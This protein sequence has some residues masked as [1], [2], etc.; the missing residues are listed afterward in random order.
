MKYRPYPRYKPSGIDWLGD[1]PEHWDVLPLARVATDIQTGPFGSQLH[2]TDY[3]EDGTPIIN[4]VH[5][6]TDGLVP[7]S[8]ETVTLETVARLSRHKLRVS[9]VIFA[10]RGEIGRCAYVTEAEAGWLCGTGCMVARFPRVDPRYLVQVFRN[11]GFAPQLALCAVGSTMPNLNS[12]ILGRMIVP[13]PPPLEQVTIA[14]YLCREFLAIDRLISQKRALIKKLREKRRAL[15]SQTVTRGL[16]PEAARTAGLNPSPKIKASGVEWIGDLPEHWDLVPLGYLGRF[17]GGATPAK[18]NPELWDG[19]IPW[20]SPKDMKRSCLFEGEDHVSELAMANSALSII[21]VGAILIVVRGMILAHSFPVAISGADL[22]INQDMKA[23]LCGAR[24]CP[25]FLFWA[26]SGFAK[27]F[28]ALAE[29]SAHGT[30]RLDTSVLSKFLVP[31]PNCDEQRAIVDFLDR[32]ISKIDRMIAKIEDAI[33]RLQE[34]R[35]ALIT[36]A[37]TGKIDVREA[38]SAGEPAALAAAAQ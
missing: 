37:V 3:V 21:P 20:I 2:Q 19:D 34:Y 11:T 17:R 13:I 36:A 31:V 25:N 30:R 6:G 10:R 27:A 38:A 8:G 22:T 35:T 5:I 33:S 29:E 16:P 12:S 28:V 9:D 26:L 24:L 23:I 15:I 4:P 14:D 18:E 1:V 7:G 32:E